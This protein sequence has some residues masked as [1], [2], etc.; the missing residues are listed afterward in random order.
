MPAG[1][2]HRRRQPGREL[3]DAE[4]MEADRAAALQRHRAGE[5]VCRAARRRH[6]EDTGPVRACGDPGAGFVQPYRGV[7]RFDEPE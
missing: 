1:R 2:Q 3:G 4:T 7:R 6:D 5:I